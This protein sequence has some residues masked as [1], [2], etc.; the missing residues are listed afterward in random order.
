MWA[1]RVSPGSPSWSLSSAQRQQFLSY[2]AEQQAKITFLHFTCNKI[3]LSH[4]FGSSNNIK[5]D[6]CYCGPNVALR[7][8]Y[9]RPDIVMLR[10][11]SLLLWFVT[12]LQTEYVVS[13]LCVSGQ[14][15]KFFYYYCK[16]IGVSHPSQ[17]KYDFNIYLAYLTIMSHQMEQ[18]KRAEQMSSWLNNLCVAG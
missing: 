15:L 3:I 18:K 9:T 5:D 6:D 11:N 16:F 13:H 4:W 7:P 2:P 14:H 8:T 17:S 1:G 10:S 12:L